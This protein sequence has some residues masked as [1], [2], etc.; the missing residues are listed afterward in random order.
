[1]FAPLFA[2]DWDVLIKVGGLIVV[3]LDRLIFALAKKVEQQPT[4]RMA[5]MEGQPE[6]DAAQPADPLQAE[7]DEFLRKA[8]AQ[9][10]G[11]T[12][13]FAQPKPQTPAEPPRRPRP[14]RRPVTSSTRR[15]SP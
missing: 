2:A 14:K 7:I 13:D 6:M 10:E 3:G 15:G 11:R 9:R 12:D 5:P 4:G 1:M 8:Q